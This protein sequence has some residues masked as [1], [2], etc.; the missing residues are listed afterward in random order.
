MYQ[1]TLRAHNEVSD[2]HLR[3]FFFVE[4]KASWDQVLQ[5]VQ[6]HILE[7][8]EGGFAGRQAVFKISPSALNLPV[9]S[10]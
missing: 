6:Q 8:S 10:D 2:P 3:F 9:K 7:G 4:G 1:S 5:H